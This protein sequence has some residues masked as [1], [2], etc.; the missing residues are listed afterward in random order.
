MGWFRRN[1][2]ACTA[3]GK[4]CPYFGIC[5]QRDDKQIMRFLTMDQEPYVEK[6]IIPW[7]KLDLELAA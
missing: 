2:N 6:E 1:S 5:N 4:T 7:I 3:F